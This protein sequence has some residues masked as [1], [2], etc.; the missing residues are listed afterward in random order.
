VRAYFDTSAFLKLLVQEPGSTTALGVW[1]TA[2]HVA[3]ASV[4]FAEASAGLAA[5]RRA[6]RLTAGAHS[7]S[8]RDLWRCWA[9]LEVVLPDGPLCERAGLLAERERLRGYD[10]VHLAAALEYEA[11]MLVCGDGDLIDAALNSGIGVID[12]RGPGE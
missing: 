9:D 1:H 12:A 6:G 11:D 5:A 2:L 7:S 10:A 3:A 4:L 8:R